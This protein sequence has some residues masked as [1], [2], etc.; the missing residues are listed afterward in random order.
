MNKK[1]GIKAVNL[2]EYFPAFLS[3]CQNHQI[4]WQEANKDIFNRIHTFLVLIAKIKFKNFKCYCCIYPHSISSEYTVFLDI[5]AGSFCM[6]LT[7]IRDRNF[8]PNDGRRIHMLKDGLLLLDVP[9]DKLA[10]LRQEM[11]C[12]PHPDEPS[13]H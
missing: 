6:L 7:T 8:Y 10:I 1:Y 4:T 3:D 2:N 13:R 9:Q 12:P 5:D 11:P